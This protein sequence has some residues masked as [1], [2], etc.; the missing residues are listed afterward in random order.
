M[1]EIDNVTE[2]LDLDLQEFPADSQAAGDRF[3]SASSRPRTW[4]ARQ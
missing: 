2:L 4:L 3:V 1:N